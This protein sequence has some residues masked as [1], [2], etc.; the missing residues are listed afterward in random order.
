[1][2]KTNQEPIVSQMLPWIATGF[3]YLM[4]VYVFVELSD[5]PTRWRRLGIALWPI[6][7]L[8]SL[9]ARIIDRE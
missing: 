4:G 3:V 6:G 1:M 8:A 9:V 2:S 7:M 5:R